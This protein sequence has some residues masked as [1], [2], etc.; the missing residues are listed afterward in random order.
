VV[1]LGCEANQID[2]IPSIRELKRADKISAYTIQ[3]KGGTGKAC[4]RESRA[5][6]RCCP[7]RTRRSAKPSREP[8]DPGPA[9]RRLRRLLGNQR[10]P[11]ARRRGGSAG[12]HGG[13][14]ILSETP[15][16]Y[17]ASTCSRGVPCRAKS[18]RN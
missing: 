9:V 4:A 18:E 8:P 2:R 7:K 14:A 13:T 15:E 10:E 16:I 17:G 11:G 6:K 1:G 3:E 12:R 5:S